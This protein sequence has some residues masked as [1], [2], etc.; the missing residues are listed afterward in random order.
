MEFQHVVVQRRHCEKHIRPL[1]HL[2]PEVP[3]IWQQN[4]GLESRPINNEPFVAVEDGRDKC[5]FHLAFTF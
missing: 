5:A 3:T 1:K 2:Q 4:K